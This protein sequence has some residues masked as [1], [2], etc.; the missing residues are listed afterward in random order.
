[1]PSKVKVKSEYHEQ[2]EKNYY[3]H[4][5]ILEKLQKAFLHMSYT[6]SLA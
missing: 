4:Q 3:K 6:L 1:M 2:I 5:R